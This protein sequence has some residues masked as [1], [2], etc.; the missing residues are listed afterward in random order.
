MK[1]SNYK[2]NG[3]NYTHIAVLID[4][5]GLLSDYKFGTKKTLENEQFNGQLSLSYE[6]LTFKQATAKYPEYFT[7]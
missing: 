7:L 5:T 4:V 6:I 2:K 3:Y 1:L